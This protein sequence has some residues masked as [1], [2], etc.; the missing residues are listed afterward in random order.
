MK[1]NTVSHFKQEYFQVDHMNFMLEKDGYTVLYSNKVLKPQLF[2]WER[3]VWDTK[4][5]YCLKI[6]RSILPG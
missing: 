4:Y 3:R 2:T 5:L 6:Y 1:A